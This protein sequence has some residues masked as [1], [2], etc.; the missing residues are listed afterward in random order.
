MTP[1]NKTISLPQRLDEARSKI[2]TYITDRPGVADPDVIAFSKKLEKHIKWSIEMRTPPSQ[3]PVNPIEEFAAMNSDPI[4]DLIAW[5]ERPLPLGFFMDKFDKKQGPYQF[6]RAD[7][8]S[9]PRS[10]RRIET[11]LKRVLDLYDDGLLEVNQQGLVSY[12]RFLCTYLPTNTDAKKRSVDMLVNLLNGSSSAHAESAMTTLLTHTSETRLTLLEAWVLSPDFF[13]AP[14][15]NTRINAYFDHGLS[16]NTLNGLTLNLAMRVLEA[17]DKYPLLH[18]I[19]ENGLGTRTESLRP[20]F[21]DILVQITNTPSEDRK[22]T[23]FRH[24][25]HLAMSSEVSRQFFNAHGFLTS[26]TNKSALVV[27]FKSVFGYSVKPNLLFS[28]LLKPISD[29][30]QLSDQASNCNKDLFYT[31]IQSPS[32]ESLND[33]QPAQ[34]HLA[35]CAKLLGL[36]Y[37]KVDHAFYVRIVEKLPSKITPSDDLIEKCTVIKAILNGLLRMD[38]Q[39]IDTPTKKEAVYQEFQRHI[40]P[41]RT[42][43]EIKAV[44]TL[45]GAQFYHFLCRHR[46]SD[47]I[48][49]R[50]FH[51]LNPHLDIQIKDGIIGGVPSLRQEWDVPLDAAETKTPIRPEA[52]ALFEKGFTHIHNNQMQA[53]SAVRNLAPTKNLFLKLKTGQGKSLIAGLAALEMLSRTGNNAVDRVFVFTSYTHLMR[54][55]FKS[56][57]FLAPGETI[58]LEKESDLYQIPTAKII[59][60]YN[61]NF[62]ALIT[63][64]L[65]TLLLKDQITDHD[66]AVLSAIWDVRRNG[67]ILDEGDLMTKDHKPSGRLSD[68]SNMFGTD[69]FTMENN[70]DRFIKDLIKEPNFISQID[71]SFASAFTHWYR[72]ES[73]C[74]IGGGITT[75]EPRG[76]TIHWAKSLRGRLAEGDFSF[77][78]LDFDFLSYIRDFK[79]CLFL[80]GSIDHN[81]MPAF[82]PLYTNGKPN[83]FVNIPSFYGT[84]NDAFY[85]R[86]ITEVTC[87]DDSDWLAKIQTDVAEA[88]DREQPVLVF[89]DPAQLER[90]ASAIR[91]LS[92]SRQDL[93]VQTVTDQNIEGVD[94][95]QIDALVTGITQQKTVTVATTI[96]GRGI[97]FKVSKHITHGMH[98]LIT[99]LP[100]HANNRLLTQMKGRTARDE[101]HGSYSIVCRENLATFKSQADTNKGTP[102]SVSSKN[103]RDLSLAHHFFT[104][105]TQRH[106]QGTNRERI[107]KR[108]IVL[109][110]VLPYISMDT[111]S[112]ETIK[113]FINSDLFTGL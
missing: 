59:H 75:D 21:R 25:R 46:Y 57:A 37:Q 76:I 30:I 106:F 32:A 41:C 112:E 27:L 91:D 3:I 58:L 1:F 48:C 113:G 90:I 43:D 39:D 84:H 4:D 24:I 10:V 26:L 99:K 64:F 102:I 22:K 31:L 65:R 14:D 108:W 98:V 82:D 56:T 73:G 40:A 2:K 50:W 110:A 104:Q 13:S 36:F 23:L 16:Q 29:F 17:S 6:D 69:H 94:P 52:R 15:S 81:D 62:N 53:L 72:Y 78:L 97:D 111:F 44:S 42:F 61:G 83:L 7:K 71:R 9:A 18:R 70:R 5:T 95:G 85:L 68:M 11:A 96:L 33:P 34:D 101:H 45:I 100:D 60:A 8:A 67:L 19:F 88:L 54:Q 35:S 38:S 55:N 47:A 20:F 79:E 92:T 63:S 80:S 86:K 51:D 28:P 12:I 93:T 89:A 77:T 87:T 109:N 107:A 103:T 105:F 74:P 66:K 49:E